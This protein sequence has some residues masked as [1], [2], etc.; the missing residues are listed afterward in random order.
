MGWTWGMPVGWGECITVMVRKACWKRSCKRPGCEKITAKL[1]IN[2]LS[3]TNWTA[4][5]WLKAGVQL[6][7][8][9]NMIMNLQVPLMQDIFLKFTVFWAVMLYSLVARY[10]CFRATCRLNLCLLLSAGRHYHIPENRELHIHCHEN[11]TSQGIL[12]LTT[13]EHSTEDSDN[14]ISWKVVVKGVKHV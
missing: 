7:V 2:Y 12:W 1:T 9:V 4:F 13:W 11:L 6:L 14:G 5:N 3:V 10:Q 8:F